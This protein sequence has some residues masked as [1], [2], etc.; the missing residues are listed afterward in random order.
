M[1]TLKRKPQQEG[2]SE[3]AA[4]ILRLLAEGLSDR[5]IAERLVMTINTVKWYNRQIYSILGVSSRTQAIA[6]ARDLNLLDADDEAEPSL[7][8]LPRTSQPNLPVEPTHFIGRR[9]EIADLK[10]L[11]QTARLLTLVGPPGTGKTRLSLRVAREVADIFHEGAYFVSLAPIT[12]PDLVV[13]AIASAIGVNEA[14]GQPLTTTLKQVLREHQML[15]VLDN[16]E[17]LLPSAPQVSELLASAPRL[18][19]LATS[20]E[21]LRLYGEQQYT[22][23]PLELPNPEYL[24]LQA[25]ADCESTALFIQQARAVQSDFELTTENALEI[26]KICV[27]LEGLPLAI[28]LAAARS[29]LLTPRALLV[30]LDSRLNTLI[31][32]IRDLPLRQQT[33]RHTIDWSYNLLNDDEK[34]LFARLAVFRGGRSLQAIEMICGIGFP[35]DPLERIESLL[36]KNLLRQQKGEDGEPRFFMLETLHEYAWERLE[37]SGEAQE[38]HRRHAEYFARLAE[39]AEPELRQAGF[40][41]WMRQLE[42]EHANLLLA[43]NWSLSGDG[44][45]LG[46]RLVAALRDFWIMSG[47]FIEG[48]QWTQRGL[49]VSQK[50]P[51]A[52]RAR[53]YIAAGLVLFYSSQRPQTKQLLEQAVELSREVDDRLIFAWALIFLGGS[54]M[55]QRQEFQKAVSLAEEG[56]ALFRELG[57]KPGMVQAFCCVGEL[58]RTNG[59]DEKAELAFVEALALSRETGEKRHESMMLGNLGFI[60]AHRGDIEHAEQLFR[61]SLITALELAIDRYI[62]VTGLVPLASAIAARG[63]PE[64]AVRLYGAAEAMLELMGAGLQASDQAE[65]ERNLAFVRQ[66]LDEATFQACWNEGRSLS[67]EHAVA[68]AL[69]LSHSQAR[70]D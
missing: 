64:R 70:H 69:E 6:R 59:D 46:L 5:E 9:R 1:V 28:E 68:Y 63:Q 16:F 30:R 42:T 26:A 52:L 55:G 62:I 11:L 4:E 65:Y 15:L 19:V 58:T 23:P 22:V 47:R 36:N 40:S 53:V 66:H 29:R 57:H 14:H 50:H 38:M 24:D 17:H 18:T 10:R 45:E 67:L 51:P 32:G 39:R 7:K 21:P 8:A 27:R 60:A 61:E 31:G 54:S 3:R 13:N 33:L 43:L 35:S 41:Y 37:A 25:L 2:L 56:L 48:E 34:M 49:A 12:D 44:T 20:R